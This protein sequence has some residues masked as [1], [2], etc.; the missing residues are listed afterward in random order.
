MT[1]KARIGSPWTK[2]NLAM[3]PR[4]RNNVLEPSLAIIERGRSGTVDCSFCMPIE[5][6]ICAVRSPLN[7]VKARQQMAQSRI[8]KQRMERQKMWMALLLETPVMGRT[9]DFTSKKTVPMT[10]PF[11]KAKIP[12]IE[13]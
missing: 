6:W 8:L 9:P 10:S 13:I 5:S 7:L 11:K 2:T 12:V 1:H 3:I 4:R